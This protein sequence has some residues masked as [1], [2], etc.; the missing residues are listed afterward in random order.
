M[1]APCLTPPPP[2]RADPD[3]PKTGYQ[4]HRLKQRGPLRSSRFDLLPT[5]EK[6][7]P[8]SQQIFQRSNVLVPLAAPASARHPGCCRAERGAPTNSPRHRRELT[9]RP[10]PLARANAPAI[11]AKK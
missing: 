7:G 1:L 6:Q 9:P 11:S 10:P 5:L 8:V 2:R 3:G 4:R